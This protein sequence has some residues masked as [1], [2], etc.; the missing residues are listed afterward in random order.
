M[1]TPPDPRKSVVLRLFLDQDQSSGVDTFPER[2][3]TLHDGR[4]GGSSITIGRA[5]K[6]STKG[7]IA[8]AENAWF[9]SPV[10]SRLHARLS[11]KLDDRKLEIKDLGSLH[12][13]FL[14]D[15]QHLSAHDPVELRQGDVLRFG[16]PIWRGNEQFVPIVVKV[17]FQFCTPDGGACTFQVPDES[18]DEDLDDSQSD[19]SVESISANIYHAVKKSI[20]PAYTAAT[21]DDLVIDLAGPP[22]SQPP[23]YA[24]SLPGPCGSQAH[25]HD[26]RESANFVEG[27]DETA[28]DVI[29]DLT[30]DYKLGGPP[31]DE[32]LGDRT[33]H[34]YDMTDLE[35]NESPNMDVDHAWYGIEEQDTDEDAEQDDDD[36]DAEQDDE[37]D[38]P[39]E[40]SDSQMDSL[41]SQSADD[42]IS[43][44]SDGDFHRSEAS[45][46]S[47]DDSLGLESTNDFTRWEEMSGTSR[48]P[49]FPE[50][51]Q[52]IASMSSSPHPPRQTVT[53]T[54]TVS[55]IDWLLNSEKPRIPSPTVDW[56]ERITPPD[57]SPAIMPRLWTR[58]VDDSQPRGENK[59]ALEAQKAERSRP[60]S[61]KD[62]CNDDD[63]VDR[64]SNYVLFQKPHP[65]LLT[66]WGQMQIAQTRTDEKG[67]DRKAKRK[68]EDISTT[69]DAEEQWAGSVSEI[70]SLNPPV[71]ETNT[72]PEPP[73]ETVQEVITSTGHD[74]EHPTIGEPETQE[75]P[76]KR[77]RMMRVA[78]RLGYAALGGVTA[79]A[80]IVGTLIY[81]APTFG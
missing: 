15:D 17:D 19:H 44:V 26:V 24:P 32:N 7:F 62:L 71:D 14:N 56:E 38:Y 34:P 54:N 20:I 66:A 58:G 77:A 23:R 3:I 46:L 64:S 55:S 31:T 45:D 39:D 53:G 8:S 51:I 10:M 50:I 57:S 2:H 43:I 33:L 68:A 63:P 76:V 9:D 40:E 79:G 80:M 59:V 29:N 75:R 61:V 18:D 12:G 28:D 42:M 22:T 74:G 27:Q 1:N 21:G 41:E 47:D 48:A 5:S 35:S 72:Q 4:D 70:P 13:T 60:I 73:A 11:A 36:Q 65:P 49:H 81:T 69:T 6:L 25:I 78:E 67:I 52:L 30:T 16:A 37:D